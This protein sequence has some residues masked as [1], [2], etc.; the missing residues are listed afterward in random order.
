[1]RFEENPLEK[2]LHLAADEPGNRPDFYKMLLESTVYI[3]GHSDQITAGEKTA[4]AGDKI[5]IQNW[6]RNDG[7]PIIPFFTSINA[8]QRAIDTET[9]YI[10]LPARSLFEMTKG[11]WLVLNPKSN[12]GKEFTPDEI[13]ALL[14][15]GMSRLPEQRITKQ[16]TQILLG[17]PKEYP[18]KMVDSL[19]TLFAKRSNVKAAYLALMHDPSLDEKPH[20]LI[21]VEADGNIEQV[22]QEAGVVAGDT[23]PRGEPVDMVRVIPG[24]KDLSDY[25]KKEVKPFYERGLDGKFKSLFGIGR[26]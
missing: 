11:T 2:A 17:Q 9:S 26:A 20:L 10:A 22:L 12:Y 3:L 16:A 5:S 19:K 6:V 1:M 23:S 14:S 21:G 18:N 7:S 8:L 25:F 4:Q 13:N 24:K 15:A